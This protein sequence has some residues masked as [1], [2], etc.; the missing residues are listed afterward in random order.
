MRPTDESLRVAPVGK[1]RREEFSAFAPSLGAFAGVALLL[2]LL[3]SPNA[4][5]M[6][7]FGTIALACVV[8]LAGGMIHARRR[9]L[10]A[11]VVFDETRVVFLG[12]TEATVSW[13]QLGGYR[14]DSAEWIELVST[15]RRGHRLLVPTRSEEDRV[16]VL[17]LLDRRGLR[18]LD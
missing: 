14:D 15:S 17:E 2:L 9:T 3:Q 5:D 7:L 6:P 16:A 8:G 4:N 13:A 1:K 12:P 18:R 11:V 10:D